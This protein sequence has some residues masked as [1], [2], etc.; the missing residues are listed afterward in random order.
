MR[1]FANAVRAINVTRYR[2]FLGVNSQVTPRNDSCPHSSPLPS[3]SF[4]L[5]NE[6]VVIDIHSTRSV[7]YEAYLLA[8][9][10]TIG[11][12]RNAIKSRAM[13]AVPSMVNA[14]MEPVYAAKDGTEGTAH[15]VRKVA[16]CTLNKRPVFARRRYTLPS[17]ISFP[18]QNKQYFF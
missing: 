1:N 11:P 14:R 18:T 10:T 4:P 15:Y 8:D 13:H 7:K 6:N 9:V 17:I 2:A 3:L 5:L 16:N 12:E